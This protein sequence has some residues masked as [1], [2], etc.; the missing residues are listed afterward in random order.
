VE[1]KNLVNSKL[2]RSTSSK[3]YVIIHHNRKAKVFLTATFF[4]TRNSVSWNEQKIPAL[5]IAVQSIRNFETT[6]S[7][8]ISGIL[9]N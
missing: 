2:I 3:K 8:I 9:Q 5:Q 1:N 7:N 4:K 6:S